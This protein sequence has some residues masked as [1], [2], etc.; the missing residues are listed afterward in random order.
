MK[1]LF[2]TDNFPPEVNAAASRVYERAVYWAKWGHDVTV[3]TCAPN[4][5]QGKV[6]PGYKNKWRQTEEMNGIKVIRVK[7][8]IAKNQ[9]F[10][11]R[12][13][14]FISYMIMAVLNG[15]FL[16]KPDVI[17]S[18]SPQFFT[19]VGGY[20][21]SVIKRRPFVFEIGDLWPESIRAV[22]ALKNEKLYRAI[23]KLELY[24]YR[25]SKIIIAQ[26][27]AFKLN[28]VKRGVPED[29]IK[30]VMNG[31]DTTIYRPQEKCQAKLSHF[32][33]N[34]DDFVV[35]YVG[36]HGMAHDLHTVLKSAEILNA[37]KK[38]QYL[39][40]GEGAAKKSLV[41]YKKEHKLINVN[42]YN[43][44]PK[45]EMP[46]VWSVCDIILIPL[47]NDETFSTVVPSKLFEAMAMAKLIILMAPEGEASKIIT[48]L[49]CGKWIES[50]NPGL[51]AN[52]IL[53][54]YR[55]GNDMKN[56]AQNALKNSTLYTR[57][58]QSSQ[59]INVLDFVVK[60]EP[61]CDKVA[62]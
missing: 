22:G 4:F 18:T 48:Q 49:E 44:V 52:T 43:A 39:F 30:V 21:L 62:Q 20:L 3:I 47:K 1:I 36:T 35:A 56:Y 17:I 24:L 2:L 37:N 45:R 7:T 34:E 60:A 59:V 50:E 40:V 55:S 41:D 28:L 38:I 58:N 31:V 57:E 9:G 19:A 10:I 15:A 42:F 16:K 46:A 61:D 11:L 53:N 32:Q 29:K 23:E 25:K 8:F 12:T 6:Y 14:D 27:T 5:P 13:L 51:L 54:L 26:T 33:L